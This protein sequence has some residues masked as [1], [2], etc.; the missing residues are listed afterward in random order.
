[1]ATPQSQ[2]QSENSLQL[3]RTF[4][5]PRERVFRAWIDAKEFAQ[6]FHP[7]IDHTT[8]IT[9]L[10]VKV[11][12]KYSLEMHHKN[13]AVHRLSGS[14]QQIKPP[15]KLVFT[16]RWAED[17]HGEETLVSL[18]FRDLGNSTEI[19]LNHG[20]FPSVESREKHNHG[21]LGCMD[22]LSHYLG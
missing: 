22:Q 11:G 9:L 8:V 19:I 4:P 14:Y 2:P 5:A 3:R 12:G 7:T 6:W 20:Q 21:W 13:G 17:P 1:M 15:E 16:W 10:D 18:E